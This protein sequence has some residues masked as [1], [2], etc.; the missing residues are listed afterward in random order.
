MG[1][2]ET[3]VN[4]DGVRQIL[5]NLDSGDLVLSASGGQHVEGVAHDLTEIVHHGNLLKIRSRGSSDVRLA[6]P[7]GIDL[8]VRTRGG[9]VLARV[10]LGA[11]RVA[12]ASGDIRLESVT[13]P[14]EL[15][16]GSGDI[17]VTSTGDTKARTGSG[18]ITVG[19]AS[20]QIQVR[21]GSGDITVG[22]NH[23][24]AWLESGSGDISLGVPDG[25]AT[26]LD[27][28]SWTG[29]VSVSAPQRERPDNG[30][31]VRVHAAT[32]SGDIR[33]VRA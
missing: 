25:V 7:A 5:V 12:T 4:A 26:L 18:D 19:S 11:A 21:T 32:S 24:Y 31:Q 17:D 23:G 28:K 3:P 14:A 27:L 20:G 2:M 9:D 30:E 8:K 6:I 33:V 10:P 22:S 1:V 16:T 29:S 13:G 15:T